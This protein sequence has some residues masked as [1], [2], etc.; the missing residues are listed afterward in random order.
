MQGNKEKKHEIAEQVAGILLEIKA[1]TLDPENP[2]TFA[3]GIR[4]PIYCDNRMLMSFPDKREKIIQF[5]LE[6]IKYDK[7]EFDVIGGIAT[8]GIPHAAWLAEKLVKPM[9]YVRS[10]A[11]EHGKQNQI[12]GKLEKGQRV[13]MVED[14]I[15]TGGSSVNALN[16]VKEAGGVVE[17][18]L[19][20]T[21][22]E[23][24]KAKNAFNTAGCSVSSLTNFS[25][26]VNVAEK[27]KYINA[28]QKEIILEWNKNPRAW[29]EKYAK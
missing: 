14:H 12:E 1:I 24:E 2:Y 16:A 3:S 18:C 29:G 9:I 6:T 8:A 15:S 27:M 5:F 19:S 13:L 28:K 25:T 7:L 22:Y 21:T 10:E 26:I 17:N 11:K 20:I 23:M 4:S